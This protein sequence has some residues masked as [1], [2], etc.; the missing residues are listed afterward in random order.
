MRRIISTFIEELDCYLVEIF[1][2]S[3]TVPQYIFL[4]NKE[5]HPDGN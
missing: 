4:S 1:V 2:W 3:K 5:I